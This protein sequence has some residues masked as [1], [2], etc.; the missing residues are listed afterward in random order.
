MFKRAVSLPSAEQQEEMAQNFSEKSI[1][2]GFISKVYAIL[3]VQLLIT[4]GFIC[5]FTF[6]PE[7][8]MFVINNTWLLWTSMGLSFVFLIPMV[9]VQTL[10][11]SFPLNFIILFLFTLCEA[12]MVGMVTSLYE[13]DA[14]LIA[15]ALTAGITLVLTIFA[16]QT[17]YD[18]TAWGGALSCFLFILIAFGIIMIFIPHDGNSILQVVYGAAGALLFSLYLIYDTQMMLGGSHKYS[19]S[20]EEYVFAALALYLDV[21]NI[22]L[23]ILRIIGAAK[24]N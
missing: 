19:I 3:M 1:R 16:M 13:Q 10:R 18:F 11:R 4:V 2:H 8:E 14:V 7:G 9:C 21:L 24:K 12:V 15:V 22:F 17:K 5:F 6:L 23:Y 20:P